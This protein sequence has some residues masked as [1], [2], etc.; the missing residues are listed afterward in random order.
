MSAC[1]SARAARS[2]L[3]PRRCAD[4]AQSRT[5]FLLKQTKDATDPFVA[6]VFQLPNDVFFHVLKF[7][8]ATCDAT[9]EVI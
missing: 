4:A 5:F 1:A 7:W 9:G 2:T 8:R 3:L 6:R